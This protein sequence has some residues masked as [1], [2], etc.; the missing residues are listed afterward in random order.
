MNKKDYL[1]F[2]KDFPE[3]SDLVEK[4]KVLKINQNKISRKL[5][6]LFH[7]Y[8][9][10]PIMISKG[11]K[12]DKLEEYVKIYFKKIDFKNV[13]KVGKQLKKEDLRIIQKDKIIIAEITGTNKRTSK[14][15]KT[16]Q[17]LKHLNVRRNDGENAFG[18]FIV[19][20]DNEKPILERNN[21]PFTDDQI[22]YAEAGRYGL[23]TTLELINAFKMHKLDQLS[24]TEFESKLCSFGHINF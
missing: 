23:I 18:I 5:K 8:I 7:E 16:S 13:Q 12:D 24:L 3:I 19:N 1:D 10:L 6:T 9:F 15:S 2:T 4:R 20:H 14:D 11:V 21:K 17:I 22:K